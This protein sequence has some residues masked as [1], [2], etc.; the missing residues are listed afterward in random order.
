M[1]VCFRPVTALVQRAN[2]ACTALAQ[3]PDQAC[4]PHKHRRTV[5]EPINCAYTNHGLA[6]HQDLA[7]Y[8]S[9]P[10]IQLLHCLRFDK[11]IIGGLSTFADSFRI[12]QL[13]KER[14]PESFEMWVP[15]FGMCIQVS[16]S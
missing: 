7:Y 12:C 13:L 4:T 1:H 14:H 15:C 10:G 9:P 11:G 2:K 6:L 3:R 5:A 8:E 16:S